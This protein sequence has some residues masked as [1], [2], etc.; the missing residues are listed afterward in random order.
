MDDLAF[1]VEF[2]TRAHAGQVRKGGDI[3]Y[4]TH[5][6][7]VSDIL[8]EHFPEDESLAIAGLLHDVVEDTKV[9]IDVVDA[10]FGRAV[11]D[12]VW[13]VT[14]TRPGWTL[15]ANATPDV[16]RLKAADLLHNITETKRDIEQ[17]HFVW[18]RFAQG[19]GKLGSWERQVRFIEANLTHRS[20]TLHRLEHRRTDRDLV[21]KLRLVF[22]VVKGLAT[23][24]TDA[25][26]AA[27]EKSSVPNPVG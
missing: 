22:D 14:N 5:P 27:Q 21:E 19:R 17:G 13:G 6:Q 4:I 1:A 8:R 3:P 10:M 24:V 26:R 23:I 18:P 12:L 11:G 25:E 9:T 2:A 20:A 16:L 15:A 7:A